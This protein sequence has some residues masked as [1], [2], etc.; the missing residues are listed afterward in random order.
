MKEPKVP[1]G[2]PPVARPASKLRSPISAFFGKIAEGHAA[3]PHARGARMIFQAARMSFLHS[4]LFLE[5]VNLATDLSRFV[6]EHLSINPAT[7]CRREVHLATE[8]S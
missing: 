3:A 2:A 8:S 5:T 1:R 7:L 4:K 6:Q